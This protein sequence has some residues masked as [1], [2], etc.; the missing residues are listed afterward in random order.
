MQ[1]IVSRQQA[2]ISEH[3][4][5]LMLSATSRDDVFAVAGANGTARVAVFGIRVFDHVS[6]DRVHILVVNEVQIRLMFFR[7]HR[8]RRVW[9]NGDGSVRARR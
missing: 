7:V 9:A 5:L 4:H 1:S 2:N 6:N 8:P 3:M